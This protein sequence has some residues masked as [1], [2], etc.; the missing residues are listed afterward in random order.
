MMHT[1]AEHQ[2]LQ[3]AK[4]ARKRTSHQGKKLRYEGTRMPCPMCRSSSEVRTSYFPNVN[5][6]ESFYQCT[7][8]ECGCCFVFTGEISRILNPGAIPDPKVTIPLSSHVRREMVR[9]VLDNAGEVQ[10]QARFSKPETG[11]LFAGNPPPADTT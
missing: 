6:R 4:P 5:M 9:V 10:H 2:A 1:A 8:V 11:D 3:A 7:N